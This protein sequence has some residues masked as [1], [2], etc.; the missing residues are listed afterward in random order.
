MN[1]PTRLFPR[2]WVF[3]LVGELL[4]LCLSAFMA[5]AKVVGHGGYPWWSVLVPAGAPLLFA[6]I[7]VLVVVAIGLWETLSETRPRPDGR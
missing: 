4:G 7:L 2:L 5:L 3:L 6:L 1:H